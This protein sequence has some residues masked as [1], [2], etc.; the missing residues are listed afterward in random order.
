M[1]INNNASKLT[2]RTQVTY[3]RFVQ[4]ISSKYDHFLSLYLSTQVKNSALTSHKKKRKKNPQFTHR[5]CMCA[6]FPELTTIIISLNILEANSL[7]N[8]AFQ[9]RSITVRLLLCGACKK[10]KKKRGYKLEKI[11]SN[12]TRTSAYQYT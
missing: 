4:D 6:F 3:Q 10:E 8:D 5:P 7:E 9:P 1:L 11:F 12:V 2:E